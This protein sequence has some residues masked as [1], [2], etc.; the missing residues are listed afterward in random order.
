MRRISRKSYS[1]YLDNRHIE[2]DWNDDG[3]LSYEPN[4]WRTDAAFDED[5]GAVRYG[6][7]I[8]EF[9]PAVAAEH[10][11]SV[12][13][14]GYDALGPEDYRLWPGRIQPEDHG[15]VVNFRADLF[16]EDERELRDGIDATV[17]AVDTFATG[18]WSAAAR[19]RDTYRNRG[20]ALPPIFKG[21]EG[22]R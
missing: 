2:F 19:I 5:K 8:D 17:K 20:D 6:G 18:M 14:A 7:M 10:W 13:S 9:D 16:P 3:T 1:D 12:L 22:F 4:G 11:K 21:N 15:Q